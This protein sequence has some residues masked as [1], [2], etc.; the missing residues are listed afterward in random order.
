MSI[1]GQ[2]LAYAVMKAERDCLVG[3]LDTVRRVH[4]YVRNQ[5]NE[6]VDALVDAH[7]EIAFLKGGVGLHFV[8][9]VIAGHYRAPD[10]SA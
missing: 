9:D 5:N 10:V 7:R 1:I 6:L 4:A 8:E 3:Q 2:K